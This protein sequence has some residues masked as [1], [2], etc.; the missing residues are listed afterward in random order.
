MMVR[1]LLFGLAAW[2]VGMTNFAF[3]AA[4]EPRIAFVVGNAAYQQRPLNTA[5]ADAGLVAEALNSAGFEIVEGGDLNQADFRRTFRDFLVKLEAAGPDAIAFVYFAGYGVGFEGENYIVPADAR[6]ER[7][8][9]IPIDAIRLSDLVRPLAGAPGRAKIIA[10]DALRPHPFTMSGAP[11]PVGF[12]AV[13]A[14]PGTLIAMSSGPGTV[15]EDAPGSYGPYATAIA[16]MIREPGLDLDTMFTRIRMRTH[17]ATE[18]RQ[19]PWHVASFSDPVVLIAGEPQSSASG[20]NGLPARATKRQ[21][22]P[23]REIGAEDG[24]ALAVEE[25]SLPAYAEY[26]EAYPTSPYAPRIWAVIRARREAMCWFRALETDTPEAYW[27]YLR[28]Y[29]NG[30]YAGDAE[31]RLRRLAAVFEPPPHFAL[32]AFDDVPPPL[33]AEPVEYVVVVPPAPPPPVV[34]IGPP[35]PLFVNLSPPRPPRGPGFLPVPVQISVAPAVG[36]R[37]PRLYVP[38]VTAPPAGGP[39]AGGIARPGG[40]PGVRP[41]GQTPVG[42]AAPTPGGPPPPP[43]PAGAPKKPAIAGVPPGAGSPPPKGPPAHRGKAIATAPPPGH[44]PAPHAPPPGRARISPPPSAVHRPPPPRAAVHRP[45]PP[46]AA[47]HHPPPPLVTRPAPTALVRPP[48]QPA[49]RAAPAKN[50]QI[51]NGQKICK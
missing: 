26:V 21:P 14:P 20:S 7:D 17:Q 18:G 10:I 42:V 3:P 48:P 46:A 19:T 34:L 49:K 35:P 28:R 6:L 24:Y 22:R 5:L 45:P 47:V 29:P 16:E 36:A 1:G 31:R 11:L 32:L 15:V 40:P 38:V 2:A 25:D 39:G 27:T 23:M 44:P 9:D 30:I 37:P 8:S 13:G 50:C 51:V 12:A 33:P 43:P 41:H 4:A